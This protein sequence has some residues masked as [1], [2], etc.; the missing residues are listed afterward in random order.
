[1]TST[2]RFAQ[3]HNAGIPPTPREGETVG[4][5]RWPYSACH[6][7]CWQPPH[8]GVVISR[9]DVR[10]WAGTI[11][12][13][14]RTPSQTEVTLHVQRLQAQGL[15]LDDVPVLWSFFGTEERVYWTSPKDLVPAS[16]DQQNWLR[17]RALAF[18][19]LGMRRLAAA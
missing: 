6:P 10:A 5:R 3:L 16:Q 15:L 9:T 7:D 1:M 18:E 17:E 13:G 11:A 14:P 2:L 8:Q 12:F 4:S 19:R